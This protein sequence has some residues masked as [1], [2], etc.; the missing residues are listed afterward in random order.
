MNLRPAGA[1]AD[2][3][4]TGHWAK[5]ALKEAEKLGARARR[6]HDRGDELRPRARA[7]GAPAR[8]AGRLPALHL[9]QHDPRHASGRPSPTPPDGRAAGVRHVVRL[10]EPA[11]RHRAVRRSIYAGAQKNLGPAGVTLVIV[12]ARAARAR[13]RRPAG[14]ARLQAAWPRTSRS[15]TR[16]RASRSTWWGWCSSGCASLGGLAA[17]GERNAA[18][19]ALVYER[20]R[21]QRRLLPRPRAAAAAARAMNVTFRLP[22]RGAGEGILAEARGRGPRRPQGPSL[23]RRAARL[24]LQRLPQ[25]SAAALASFMREF[26]RRRG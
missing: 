1:S 15:T 18:K 19:A 11:A 16:R 6:R 10:P 26:R 17:I 5:A 12:R 13:C 7:G 23:G 9:E 22:T 4:V 20:H 2:Y 3:V 14:D 8:P 24:A 21:R 25:E